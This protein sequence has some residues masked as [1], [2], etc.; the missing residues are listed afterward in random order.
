MGEKE[1]ARYEKEV[2]KLCLN[3]KLP[4]CRQELCRIKVRQSRLYRQIV[5]REEVIK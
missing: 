4:I 5:K 1:R 2:A 3:C